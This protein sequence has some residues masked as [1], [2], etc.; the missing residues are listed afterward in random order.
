MLLTITYRIPD[1]DAEHSARDLSWLL[2]KNPSR[3]HEFSLPM[4]KAYVCYPEQSDERTTAAL[5]LDLDPLDIARGKT[6]A[7]YRKLSDYVNDRP[8]A[9]SSFLSSAISRVFGTAMSGRCE[10][11]QELADSRL[12]LSACVY[13]L[14]VGE[15]KELL[16]E[17]FEPLGYRLSYECFPIDEHFPEWGES[18][19]ANLTLRGRVRLADLLRHLYVLIPVFDR[20][21]HYFVTESEIDKLLIHGKGWLETHPARERIVRRYFAKTRSYADIAVHRLRGEGGGESEGEAGSEWECKEEGKQEPA[22]QFQRKCRYIGEEEGAW[23]PEERCAP[24][25]QLRLEAVRQE[26][27]RCGA[28][29]VIDLGCGEGKLLELLLPVR[30]IG[31]LCGMDVSVEALEKARK[32]ISGREYSRQVEGYPGQGRRYSGDEGRS[33][34]QVKRLPELF[35]GSLLYQD[36]RICG[37]DAACAVEVIEHIMPEKLSIFEKV[38]FQKAAP[39]TIIVT[40][41]NREYNVRYHCAG[42]GM[43]RHEDHRFEWTREEFVAWTAKIC[44]QYGYEAEV[45]GIG[46]MDERYGFPTQMGVFTKCG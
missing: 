41:P 20:Q 28:S 10:M 44:G 17:I 35:Q 21:K 16:K 27:I 40:T 33:P 31:K 43:L 29:S 11:R 9:A 3:L 46:E 8:Y 7:R 38:L 5:L 23:G 18:P 12:E 25:D 36:S 45:K 6:G 2:H 15:K 19:Y 1:G 34:G 22:E 37:F 13:M 4:G 39:P 24:L 32:R 26:V 30:E 14:P 42:G